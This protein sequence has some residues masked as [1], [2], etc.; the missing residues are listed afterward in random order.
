LTP[1]RARIYTPGTT[2]QEN[3][4]SSRVLTV[5]FTDIKGFTERTSASS[6]E[7]LH[8][9]LDEHD[10]LLRPVVSNFGGTVVKTIG[11]ALLVTFE[12]PTNAVLCGVMMQET[13]REN[14]DGKPE[15]DQINIRVAI[16][17]G[18]VEIR[19][20]DVFGEAVNIAARI[21]GI[22]EASEIYF[23]ESVY[24]N[25]NK[26]EV[27]TSAVGERR[28][29][30]IPEAIKVYKVIQDR[31]SEQYM[32]LLETL[33]SRRF[34]DVP[35]PDVG[36]VP[37][38]PAAGMPN[39]MK[40]VLAASALILITV[41]AVAALGT[42]GEA[43][44]PDVLAYN[45]VSAAIQEGNLGLAL[46]RAD[47]MVEKFPE[48]E[49]SHRAAFE[50]VSA[51]AKV[52]VDKQL[53]G[54][55]LTMLEERAAKRDY[56]KVDRLVKEVL[57]REFDYWHGKEN[58]RNY[59][60]V[61]YALREKFP[62]DEEVREHMLRTCGA[63]GDRGTESFGLYAAIDAAEASAGTLT[64]LVERTL[65]DGLGME[66]AWNRTGETIRSLLAAGMQSDPKALIENLTDE[67]RDL[68]TN[69][70]MLLDSMDK[71]TDGERLTYHMNNLFTLGSAYRKDL[72]GSMRWIEGTMASENW[73]ALKLQSGIT[74]ITHCPSFDGQSKLSEPIADLLLKGWKDEFTPFLVRTARSEKSEDYMKRYAAYEL[75][76]KHRLD[77]EVDAWSF[78]R[79]TLELCDYAY[80]YRAFNAAVDFFALQAGTDKAPEAL[81]IVNTTADELAA[82]RKKLEDAENEYQLDLIAPMIEQVNQALA[83]LGGQD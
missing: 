3:P 82:Y 6:R 69:T 56:L 42:F 71:L 55:A 46:S 5:M 9:L 63:D 15:T 45:D 13:L 72:E 11:D 65:I 39:A 26:S 53:F 22:T 14:N 34:A 57:L 36:N 10:E 49:H 80:R 38:E 4:M 24:L 62:S 33:R 59:Q 68:R 16:N 44:E 7:D 37:P 43:A 1:A 32:T 51:E 83:R 66:S 48:S 61:Y 76:E 19:E 21:E 41:I 70:F 29:K 40:F 20:G 17:T 77:T 78:H 47:A 12:S 23:T 75:L 54:D 73:M 30:G 64:D 27:P 25:M 28:L 52:L 35:V 58:Y 31:N 81:A 60:S 74:E 8:Q 50:V 18:E 2:E 67:D 79:G